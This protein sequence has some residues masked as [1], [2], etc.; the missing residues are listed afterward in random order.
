MACCNTRRGELPTDEASYVRYLD[1]TI[2]HLS[3]L[4]M[5]GANADSECGR[6][7]RA[8]ASA[9]SKN[10]WIETHARSGESWKIRTA[11]VMLLEEAGIHDWAT[12]SC[13][14]RITD[15][16]VKML[17]KE[18]VNLGGAVRGD[19]LRQ[20]VV[21][22]ALVRNGAAG[23]NVP[24]TSATYIPAMS[25]SEWNTAVWDAIAIGNNSALPH[26]FKPIVDPVVG[27]LRELFG[28]DV[29][30]AGIANRRLPPMGSARVSSASPK[31]PA[32]RCA[33]QNACRASLRQPAHPC[34]PPQRCWTIS[35]YHIPNC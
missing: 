26:E 22:Q 16:E 25:P 17:A 5:Q 28:E 6:V 34:G 30:P 27:H 32:R 31:I 13:V 12:L 15:A 4:S 35:P 29:I 7:R 3:S 23:A 24:D 19:A 20:H 9:P 33:P 8:F 10:S 14:N 1:E 18:L 21:L 11:A 2:V